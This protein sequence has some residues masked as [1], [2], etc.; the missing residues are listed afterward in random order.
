MQT[1]SGINLIEQMNCLFIS[2]T[3]TGY[4]HHSSNFLARFTETFII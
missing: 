4:L 3:I 2:L 1:Y